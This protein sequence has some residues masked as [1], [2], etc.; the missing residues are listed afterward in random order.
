MTLK[1][2]ICRAL[3]VSLLALSAHSAGAGM[4]GAERAA[5][6]ESPRAVVMA[7]LERDDV[8]AQL[9]A[10]GV[11]PTEA[12]QRVAALSDHEVNQL[13]AQ[14]E[15]APAGADVGTAIA[16][17]AIAAAVWYFVFRR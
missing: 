4:I 14:I 6:R 15:S 2:T 1:N 7:T 3:I 10:Q 17:V 8:A 13:A 12:R 9:E 16:V 11:D 5:A